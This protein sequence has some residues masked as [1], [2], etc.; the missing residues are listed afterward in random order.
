VPRGTRIQHWKTGT[1]Q[2]QGRSSMIPHWVN[3]IL[4]WYTI[5]SKS[6]MNDLVSSQ[7]HCI[8]VLDWTEAIF[9]GSPP[10]TPRY[11]SKKDKIASVVK[12]N[13]I[14]VNH[15][16]RAFASLRLQSIVIFSFSVTSHYHDETRQSWLF[17]YF[18]G[19]KRHVVR[20]IP[21]IFLN[22]F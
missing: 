10:C 11:K 4:Q 18:S 2:R 15:R 20:A 5:E 3:I 22:K 9:Q 13:E 1:V 16:D 14:N 19:V 21:K 17:H 8:M 7:Y 12:R 6:L